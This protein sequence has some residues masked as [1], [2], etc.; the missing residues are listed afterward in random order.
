MQGFWV[1]PGFGFFGVR[2]LGVYRVYCVGCIGF[3]IQG[4][5]GAG[6]RGL[7]GLGF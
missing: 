3:C 4:L 1:L 5:R 7:C 2:R 6:F